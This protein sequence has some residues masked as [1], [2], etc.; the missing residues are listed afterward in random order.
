MSSLT[1]PTL[2]PATQE[3]INRDLSIA[4]KF[5]LLHDNL[6]GI[7]DGLFLYRT[8]LCLASN[9]VCGSALQKKGEAT[10]LCLRKRTLLLF[11]F[12]M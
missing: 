9:P 1:V 4:D 8:A 5:Y 6:S 11:I 12:V 10:E 3:K 7:L 2:T